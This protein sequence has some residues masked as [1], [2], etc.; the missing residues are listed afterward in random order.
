MSLKAFGFDPVSV[1]V[2]AGVVAAEAELAPAVKTDD[3]ADLPPASS[4]EEIGGL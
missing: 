4:A 3:A 1:R 2:G